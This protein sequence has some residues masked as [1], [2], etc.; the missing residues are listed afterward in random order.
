[1]LRRV[2]VLF[3]FCSG[4]GWPQKANDSQSLLA[5][6]GS[7]ART[8]TSWNA[9]G[10]AVTEGPNGQ[11]EIE[12]LHIAYRLTPQPE[13]RLEIT[14]GPNQLLRICD[15]NSQWTYYRAT[16]TYVRVML[17]KIG[18][19]AYPIN[20]WPLLASNI[21]FPVFAGMENVGPYR[22][23]DIIGKND[24]LA[25]TR[26]FTQVCIDSQTGLVVRFRVHQLPPLPWLRTYA[27]SSL[28]RNT[29]LDPDLFIF[30]PP[31]GSKQIATINWIDRI[32]PPRD[33]A[34]RISDQME[35]PELLSIVAPQIHGPVPVLPPNSSVILTAELG[36]HG[37]LQ[38][39]K[40]RP[41]L[42]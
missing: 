26:P 15:H 8:G 1:M 38:N 24:D 11:R 29:A 36:G 16:N 42:A 10:S 6:I 28:E 20:S 22:C 25:G 4:P 32:A 19:C 34:V 13:A 41:L 27:F 5:Q 30:H 7:Y 39:I 23:S 14:S 9:V 2:V 12:L 18:P 40:S 17:P 35:I 33:S 21:R 3:V 37:R 31:S